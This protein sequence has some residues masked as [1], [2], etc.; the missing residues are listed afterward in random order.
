MCGGH[1][2]NGEAPLEL[3]GKGGSSRGQTHVQHKR[4]SCAQRGRLAGSGGICEPVRRSPGGNTAA[5]LPAGPAPRPA[6]WL[7][8]TSI[9]REREQCHGQRD[10]RRSRVS[11]PRSARF[12]RR[13]RYNGTSLLPKSEAA[14]GCTTPAEVCRT[15]RPASLPAANPDIA[16]RVCA[17]P[18]RLFHVAFGDW[19]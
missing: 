10:R 11:T 7:S 1:K 17:P 5:H 19:W 18:S 14:P 13:L 4:R 6:N 9:A 12:A 8:W 3:V 2:E 15:I 16:P